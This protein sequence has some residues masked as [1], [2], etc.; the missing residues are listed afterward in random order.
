MCDANPE[1]LL[2]HLQLR[3]ERLKDYLKK[4]AARSKAAALFSS[5]SPLLSPS[6][7]QKRWVGVQFNN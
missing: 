1:S 5:R 4:E 3:R 7:E 2:R 6:Q